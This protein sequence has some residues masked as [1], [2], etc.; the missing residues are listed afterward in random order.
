VDAGVV[1]AVPGAA[2]DKLA[3]PERARADS[4]DESLR[5]EVTSLGLLATMRTRV[6]VDNWLD[7]FLLPP[8]SSATFAPPAGMDDPRRL[9]EQRDRALPS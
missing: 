1:G 2:V 5:W 4:D 6:G 7:A 3:D 9:A 8:A